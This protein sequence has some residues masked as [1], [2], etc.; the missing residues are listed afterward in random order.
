MCYYPTKTWKSKKSA[1]NPMK[2]LPDWGNPHSGPL[3][4]EKVLLSYTAPNPQVSLAYAS[5]N[6]RCYYPTSTTLTLRPT[7]LWTQ[8]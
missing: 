4:N 7:A 2:H 6:R 8:N 1:Q 3:S 5:S